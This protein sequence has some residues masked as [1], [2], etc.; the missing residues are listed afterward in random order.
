[1][2]RQSVQILTTSSESWTPLGSTTDLTRA[3]TV[4]RLINEETRNVYTSAIHVWKLSLQRN[5]GETICWLTRMEDPVSAPHATRQKPTF[6]CILTKGARTY[7]SVPSAKRNSKRAP[8]CKNIFWL[9]VLEN[10]GLCVRTAA[11]HAVQGEVW[12][13][14]PQFQTAK[15]FSAI[16]AVKHLPH[17]RDPKTQ[18]RVMS[19]RDVSIIYFCLPQKILPIS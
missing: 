14:T 11:R 3:T 10:V 8:T 7:R 18:W 9:R 1:M 16:Y 4:P 6:M 15:T 19:R 12:K 5:I 13:P 2:K 17:G